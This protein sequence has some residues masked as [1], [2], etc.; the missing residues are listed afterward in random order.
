MHAGAYMDL[1]PAT[2]RDRVLA[3]H[4][5]LRT[6]I[7]RVHRAL[8]HASVEGSRGRE[9]LVERVRALLGELEAHLAQED[10][11]L[12]PLL[13][14]IDAWGPV[15]ADRVRR[16]HTEQR[17]R[18]RQFTVELAD[19]SLPMAELMSRVSSFLELLAADMEAEERDV[20]S[21]EVLHD[22]LIVD[23]VEG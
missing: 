15:R 16:D 10:A 1:S 22:D 7:G 21:E 11:I 19:A 14:G 17:E 2:V 20:V 8:A 13:Q 5:Q 4:G 9:A 12:V 6:T 23:G 3:E 18:L